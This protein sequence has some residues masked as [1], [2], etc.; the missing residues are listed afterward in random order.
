MNYERSESPEELGDCGHFMEVLSTIESRYFRGPCEECAE[1]YEAILENSYES[2]LQ[3]L[4]Y[5]QVD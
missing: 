3:S 4:L 2:R 1:G 5:P